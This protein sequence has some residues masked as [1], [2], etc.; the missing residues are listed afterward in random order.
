MMIDRHIGNLAMAKEYGDAGTNFGSILYHPIQHPIIEGV[1]ERFH[2]REF[3]GET[4]RQAQSFLLA[5]HG[6]VVLR[7]DGVH[8]PVIE[9]G[10]LRKLRTRHTVPGK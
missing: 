7:Y 9:V 6:H 5:F 10:L 8:A 2:M 3:A 1:A 4:D